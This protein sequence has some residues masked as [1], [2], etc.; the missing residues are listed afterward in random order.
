MMDFQHWPEA[1]GFLDYLKKTQPSMSD[2]ASTPFEVL[3]TA[4][5]LQLRKYKAQD[6]QA[7]PVLILPSVINRA[8][9]LDLLPEK[10]L[11]Q[12]FLSH[13]HDVYLID[14]G[15][16]QGHEQNLS[17]ENLLTLYVDFFLKS[18]EVDS[19]GRKLHVLG[20]C[21]G[22]TIGLILANLQPDRFLSLSLITA[23]VSFLEDNK[24][25]S[26]AR[27][28]DFDLPAFTEAYGNVPWFMLQSAFIALKPSQVLSKCRQF[29]GKSK[30]ARYLRNF[31]AMEAWSNDNVNLRGGCFTVLLR[32]L[33][34]KNALQEG[35]LTIQGQK[36][37][38]CQH[39]LPTFVLLAPHDHIVSPTSHL[40]AEMVPQVKNFEVVHAE[41][42]HVGALLSGRSQKVVWPKLTEWIKNCEN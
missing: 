19:G 35:T 8:F 1:T 23:P 29:L 26:W 40:T 4:G 12:N 27:H 30:D 2:I 9:V 14:W 20:H 36:V 28:P 3:E 34:G 6:S 5:S 31:W 22:G 10:S 13:G 18:I 7:H 11:I 39:E 24:L 37:D 41:G 42:G 25:A 15:V 21:L 17:F 32:D 38:L 33:Y 16:P